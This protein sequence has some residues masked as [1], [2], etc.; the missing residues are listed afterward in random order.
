MPLP[1]LPSLDNNFHDNDNNSNATEESISSV[2]QATI[3]EENVKVFFEELRQENSE[4][5]VN[6]FRENGWIDG[7]N[8]DLILSC[9][10]IVG[11]SD[12]HLIADKPVHFTLHKDIVKRYDFDYPDEDYLTELLNGI[13]SNVQN[14][15]Y[16]KNLDF[17]FNYKIRFGPYQGRRFRANVGKTFGTHSFVFR[18]ISDVIPDTKTLGIPQEIIDWSD[19]PNGVWIIGGATGSGKST[20][21]A[22]IIHNLQ[23]RAPKKIITIER[24][25][26][27]VYPEIGQALIVQRSVGEGEDTLSFYNGLTY[28]LRQ[29]PDI[30]LIGEV[31]NKEE[32]EELIR[33]AET[34]H[35]AIST[36]HTNSV[37]TTFDR[38]F[39]L[40][41]GDEKDRIKSTLAGSL[42][43]LA[44]Q[45]LVRKKDG[46]GVFAVR[47]V[48]TINNEIRQYIED[49]NTRAIKKYMIKHGTTM[50]QQL[51]KAALDGKCTIQEARSLAPDFELFDKAIK[52][53]DLY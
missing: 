30:I 37:I 35:L 18:T 3:E 17:D 16:V 53:E 10:I 22:S 27:Y 14:S 19:L 6:T 46:T 11:A 8:L 9:A 13:L 38:I 34:G 5:A 33:A 26:E 48:L 25:I 31:R 15:M 40:F 23:M 21:L 45:N 29:N 36:I 52:K 28:A 49:G 43:G 39:S 51:A 44:N 7:I 20:T 42:R 4:F 1:K 47:E 12:I 50:E 32:V 24:P 2:D 41:P